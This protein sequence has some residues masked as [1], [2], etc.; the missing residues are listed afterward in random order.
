MK[1]LRI[2]LSGLLPMALV[3]TMERSSAA[4]HDGG[5]GMCVGCHSI[6][7]NDILSIS[8]PSL[9]REQDASSTCLFCHQQ[10]G[11][12][13][14]T[15]YHVSTPFSELAQG[16]P[17]KQ[18]TP[19]GDFGW[20]KK[21]YSWIP[22]PALAP[23]S[24]RGERHGHNIVAADFLYDADSTYSSAPGGTYPSNG[25][26][27]IS[28]HDPHGKYRRNIDGS[29]STTWSPIIAS[30]S[31]AS[32]P[33]P[34]VNKAVGVYRM[35][36]GKGYLPKALTG[37][38]AFV[39]DP[40]IAIAPDADNRSESST[41]TRV[42]YGSGMSEWCRNC[43]PDMHTIVW[44]GNTNLLHPAG[45]SAGLGAVKAG[46]YNAY[47]RT[48]D[49]TGLASTSYLSL[50]PFE[51]G[52]TDYAALKAHARSDDTWLA[53]P[54]STTAQVMCLTCHR[55]HASG[56]DGIMRWNAETN[57]IVNNGSY[58]Q[59]GQPEQPYGQGRSEAEA[60]RAYYDRPATKFAPSQDTL[61]NKCHVGV[62]P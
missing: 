51:E 8:G 60:L 42:A 46:N 32:S 19:G 30:G 52:T 35:L 13:G 21:T 54:D 2:M 43:H 18:L 59:E 29:I 15:D 61:C 58:A 26:S 1:I 28:C 17:P 44:P 12:I 34:D 55:A 47:I 25:L 27:C 48:G 41:Q 62:Y 16:I 40:P 49:L 20:L 31:F 45:I 36:G 14:P 3:I 7:G 10:P 39:N 24:S 4:F 50:V 9:L 37:G 23:L 57:Y 38:L 11:D 33:E 56:W 53:G 5:V 6:H 22:G